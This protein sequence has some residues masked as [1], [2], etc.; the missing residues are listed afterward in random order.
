MSIGSLFSGIGLLELGL[1]RAGLGGVAWQAEIDPY[2]RAVLARHWPDAVRY[3][4]V[5]EVTSEATRVGVMCGG[6]P[7]Q[8]FSVAGKRSGLSDERWLWPEYARIVEALEPATIVGENVPG[9]RGSGLRH[10]LADLA[11]LGFDAEWATFRAGD[12]GAPHS[13]NRI[14]VVATHPDRCSVRDEPGW[15]SRA[16]GDASRLASDDGR[17]WAL[18]D[19][20]AFGRD[21][22]RAESV[23]WTDD[24]GGRAEGDGQ[25]SH[26][27][28]VRELQPQGRFGALRG[29]ARD[30]G[31]RDA[32]PAVRGVD[33]GG[34]SRLDGVPDD[35]AG[36]QGKALVQQREEG[37]QEAPDAWRVSALGNAVVLQCAELVGAAIMSHVE[38]A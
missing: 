34:A 36:D 20:E 15:L 5:R 19:A 11:R 12:L 28:C 35:A 25:A 27:D 10:V 7:C 26:A 3:S 14:W 32:P 17:A 2:C 4:D 23:G 13:R 8:P 16:C 38:L 24:C 22:R 6:F 29:W 9:L 21:A 30:S 31:W 37:A 18:A 33:D 1:E